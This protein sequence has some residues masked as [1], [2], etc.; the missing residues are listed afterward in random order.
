MAGLIPRTRAAAQPAANATPKTTVVEADPS[1]EQE[2]GSTETATEVEESAAAPAAAP[3]VHTASKT[4]AVATRPTGSLAPMG[5]GRQVSPL[6]PMKNALGTL[7]WNAL[8]RIQ[9][10]NGNF[11]N[12]D[13]SNRPIGPEMEIQLLSYQDNWLISPGGQKDAPGSKEVVRYSDDG[14]FTTKGEDCEE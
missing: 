14:K 9:A 6:E 2:Q 10:T 12:Q 4:T 1:N 5:L 8:L 3:S 11:V 7:E 13:D